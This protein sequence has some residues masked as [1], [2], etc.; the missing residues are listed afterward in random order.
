MTTP[1]SVCVA[2]VHSTEVSYSFFSSML[3]LQAELLQSGRPGRLLALRYGSGGI[4]D[5]RNRAVEQFLASDED[6][7]F[8]VDT[9]MGFTADSLER[10]FVHADA[11]ERP[12]V[13]G[14]CFSNRET[15]SDGYGGFT[16]FP[17]PTIYR[18][19]K[20]PD[21]TTG[22]VS[23]HEYPRDQLIRC[24]ATGSAFLLVH[25]SVFERIGGDWYTQ[26]SNPAGGV[27]GEDISFCVRLAAN[28]IPLHID[29]AVKTTH[30][31]PTWLSEAHFDAACQV[32]G[33][34]QAA[35]IGQAPKQPANRPDRRRQ[36][37]ER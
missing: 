18:W 8:W 17:I 24:D 14:L 36:E 31:K 20:T 19:A 11:D 33:D 1:D 35:S 10:L 32:A 3:G 22:F 5:A 34:S 4:V 2:W 23:W 16:T 29:T 15:G 7:L 25:R 30:H 12:V 9:D 13:G 27:F 26:A 21:G 37:R 28:E 6:W